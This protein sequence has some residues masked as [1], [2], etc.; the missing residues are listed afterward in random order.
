[1]FQY[2]IWDYVKVFINLHEILTSVLAYFCFAGQDNTKMMI[3]FDNL[4]F[5]EV[6][7]VVT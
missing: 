6:E 3:K 7:E 5:T 2:L 4:N 1:M